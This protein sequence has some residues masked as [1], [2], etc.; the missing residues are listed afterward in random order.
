MKALHVLALAAT[1]GAC[2]YIGG[3][4]TSHTETDKPGLFGGETHEETTTT[5][6]PITNTND[7]STTETKTN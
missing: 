4:Q 2:F 5:H 6:N 3:C 1:M 7:K